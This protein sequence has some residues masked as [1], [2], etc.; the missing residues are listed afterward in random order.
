MVERT[1]TDGAVLL[2][3][4]PVEF[5]EIDGVGLLEAVDGATKCVPGPVSS[6]GSGAVNGSRRYLVAWYGVLSATRQT[7]VRSG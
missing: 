2:F 4:V 3:V 1:E 6:L 5:T 7:S